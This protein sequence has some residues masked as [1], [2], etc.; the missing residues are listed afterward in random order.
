MKLSVDRRAVLAGI[1]ASASLPWLGSPFLPTAATA[2]EAI[3]YTAWSAAV[4][5]VQS[6][7]HAFQ[8]ATGIAVNYSN[9]PARNFARPW[10][11]SLPA[12]SRSTWSG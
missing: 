3:N 4:D 5:Q 10:S 9:F 1:G 6:H 7:I 2:G 12:T 11:P 8:Q